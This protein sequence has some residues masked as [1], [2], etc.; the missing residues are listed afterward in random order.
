MY[1]QQ[2]IFFLQQNKMT[3]AKTKSNTAAIG[4][5]ILIT[6]VIKLTLIVA[7]VT[8]LSVVEVATV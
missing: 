3:A 7:F 4:T 5:Q 8:G 1:K 6:L 2:N